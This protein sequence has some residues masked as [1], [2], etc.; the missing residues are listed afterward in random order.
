V[1][2]GVQIG[3]LL[4]VM[5]AAGSVLGFLYKH[6]G[7]VESPDVNWKRPVHSTLVLFR[8]KWYLLGCVIATTSWGFHVAALSLAPISI[9][10][11]VIAGGLVLLTVFADR[12]F[13]LTV[14][15]RDW[16]GVGLAAAGLAF[17]A[18]T[19]R[20]AGDEAYSEYEL[21]TLAVFVVLT[22]VAAAVAGFASRDAARPG[23]LLGMSAGLLWAGSNVAIKAASGRIDDLGWLVA[24]QPLAV[25]IFILSI[26]GLLVSAASLQ[27]G[28]PVA[29]IA[30]TSVAANITTITSGPIVFGDPLPDDPL[31][32]VLRVLAFTFV[33]AAA[34]MTQGRAAA[35]RPGPAARE[36]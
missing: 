21:S 24:L 10:Q 17:L 9:V 6:R 8:S 16:I 25:V 27:I 14:A 2:A 1:D 19:I 4:A 30:T 36:A 28:P 33:I 35:I 23:V 13:G 32:L 20:G 15:R 12:L 22:T 26:A 3:I 34:A 31:G 5:T 7:A 11:A 18:L 29:V